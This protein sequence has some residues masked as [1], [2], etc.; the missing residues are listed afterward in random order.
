M[1]KQN[2][3]TPLNFLR[4]QSALN[5]AELARKLG[6]TQNDIGRMERQNLNCRIDKYETVAKYF[7]VPV[8]ALLATNLNGVISRLRG[9][10]G[11]SRSLQE[12]VRRRQE[13]CMRIGDKGEA[14]VHGLEMQKLVHTDYAHAVNGNYAGFEDAHFDILSFA[15]D[16]VPII[17]EVKTTV[18][19]SEDNFFISAPELE[20][21]KACM[22]SGQ[23]YEIHRVHH[24]DDE[25]RRGRD[26]IPAAVL[27]DPNQ[28]EFVPTEYEVRRR[29]AC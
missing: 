26:I 28:Y 15:E 24:V 20:K 12:R 11:A 8:D 3:I 17:I 14:Y 7:C 22:A 27:L 21:A 29:E 13:N 9:R 19:A 16:G 18:G 23:R 5:R 6:L 2:V 1:Q 25:S 10:T 4:V